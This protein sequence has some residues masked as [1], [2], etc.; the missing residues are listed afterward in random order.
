MTDAPERS[1]GQQER[2]RPVDTEA[3][4]ARGDA[5]DAQNERTPQVM[6][7]EKSRRD[8]REHAR[9]PECA[10]DHS[11]CEVFDALAASDLRQ[12]NG[13]R[14]D[15]KRVDEDDQAEKLDRPVDMRSHPR[16]AASAIATAVSTWRSVVAQEHTKR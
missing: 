10:R 1:S 3:D 15:R 14:S 13:K 16:A 6:R 2:V 5:H 9:K 4:N 7:D 12:E 11:Q 8:V